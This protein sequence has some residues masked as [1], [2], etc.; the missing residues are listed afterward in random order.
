[1][2][3]IVCYRNLADVGKAAER[4]C[5]S[6]DW[7]LLQ[8]TEEMIVI[9]QFSRTEMNIVRSM[10]IDAGLMAVSYVKGT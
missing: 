4:L 7:S 5:S 10:S 1:M 3:E 9:G 8:N 6:S 2:P